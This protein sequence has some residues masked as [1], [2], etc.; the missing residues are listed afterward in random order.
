M[1]L[2]TNFVKRKEFVGLIFQDSGANFASKICDFRMET[3]NKNTIS[4]ESNSRYCV[5]KKSRLSAR[6]A[7]AKP[8]HSKSF[9]NSIN[10]NIL[11][12]IW[13]EKF[14]YMVLLP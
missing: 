10:R 14:S 9:E 11:N 1:S 5:E 12:S 4:T 7:V 6:A 2:R 13:T 8:R 3:T